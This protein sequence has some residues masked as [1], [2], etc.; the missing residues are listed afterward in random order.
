MVRSV[1]THWLCTGRNQ[2]KKKKKKKKNFSQ[3]F[4]NLFIFQELSLGE[5]L[6]DDLFGLFE[7]MSAIEM[8]DPKMDAGMRCNRQERKPHT[9]RS[10][11]AAG[12]VNLSALRPSEHVGVMDSTL[13]CLV[14]WFEGHSLAQTVFTNLYL[15]NVPEIEDP[16]AKSFSVVVL[17]L[18]SLV[19]DFVQKGSVYEEE[20][21]QP[22]S[23]G[24]KLCADVSEHRC[25]GMLKEV[26]DDLTARLVRAKKQE[27]DDKEAKES[28]AVLARVRFL[29]LFY[30][31][32]CALYRHEM[33][34]GNRYLSAAKE[35]ICTIE[36]TV[37]LG[38]RPEEEN[39]NLMGFDRL[40]N[41]RLL[42]PT[43]PRY[44]ETR[45]RE[46]GIAYFGVLVDRLIAATS[47]TQVNTFHNALEFFIDYSSS[48]PCVLSRSVLQVLY[49]PLH[50]LPGH[51]PP[52]ASLSLS[53]SSRGPAPPQLN[54]LL[55]D[56]C[57]T[58]IAPPAI[59]Y[60][61]PPFS[62]NQVNGVT[63]V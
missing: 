45:T 10:G 4:T 2:K 47:V 7:A 16:V 40:V 31:G 59:M 11:V 27:G 61:T 35:Q 26:E 53:V 28:R 30:S 44:T 13:A 6:H 8:M 51:A 33:T 24:F 21:F 52:V 55:R 22:M 18:I 62:A 63:I 19:K 48:G 20:D 12:H 25:A 1:C 43:F 29:R 5:L 57:K 60:K 46:S 54:D 32:L 3:T 17:K 36:E 37:D 49:Q 50:S 41:Q 34:E 38:I 15:H 23:Y 42:P 56:A 39:G 9:F 14:T 58:F